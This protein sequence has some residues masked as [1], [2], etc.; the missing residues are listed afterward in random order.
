MKDTI[1]RNIFRFYL[2]ITAASLVIQLLLAG[3]LI[4]MNWDVIKFTA[5]SDDENRAL[6]DRNPRPMLYEDVQMDSVISRSRTPS[7]SRIQDEERDVV[8]TTD[9]G[10]IP[11]VTISPRSS[12]S[13]K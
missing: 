2:P 3:V 13:Y 5:W 4:G 8:D 9:K 7:R 1:E 11:L 12:T 10:M 6:L